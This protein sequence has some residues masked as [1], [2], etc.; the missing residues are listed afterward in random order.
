MGCWMVEHLGIDLGRYPLDHWKVPRM[1][2][3]MVEHLE[4][5]LGQYQMD[6]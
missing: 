6:G 4:I 3:W 5:D 2:C 1:A